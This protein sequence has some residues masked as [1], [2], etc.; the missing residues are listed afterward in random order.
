MSVSVVIPT[1]PT[2]AAL[3]EIALDSVKAQTIPPDAVHVVVDTDGAGPAAT[4]N[5]GLDFVDT[6]WVAFLDDD[7]VLKPNHLRALAR[8]AY[9]SGA[10][11]VYPYF[12]VVG[13]VDLIDCFAVPFDPILLRRRNYIP[14]TVLAR[15]QLVRMVG[16]FEDHPDESGKPCEDWGLWLKLLDHGARF[17]H[18]PQRTWVWH[19]RG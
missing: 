14:V 2:R 17:S 6:D 16:G 5:H 13:G 12:D 9:L 7:D 15:T 10:D 1:I 18:L 19:L 11:V 8:Y 3:L 4:R